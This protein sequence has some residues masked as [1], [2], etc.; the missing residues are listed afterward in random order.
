[1]GN[2]EA[3]ALDLEGGD[4]RLLGGENHRVKWSEVK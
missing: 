3:L 2:Y 1:M 4:R